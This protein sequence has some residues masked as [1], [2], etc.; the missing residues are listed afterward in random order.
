MLGQAETRGRDVY[1]HFADTK[2]RNWRRRALLRTGRA[3]HRGLHFLDNK[4]ISRVPKLDAK[5]EGPPT[6]TTVP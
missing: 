4:L 1:A 5:P 6:R 3:A 2:K